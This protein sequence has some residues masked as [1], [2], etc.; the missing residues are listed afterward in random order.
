M[1]LVQLAQRLATRYLAVGELNLLPGAAQLALCDAVNIASTSFY[2]RAPAV[3]RRGNISFTL[4]APVTIANVAVTQN[5]AQLGAAVFTSDQTGCTVQL[6]GDPNWN[7]VAGPDALV[8]AYLGTQTSVQATVYGDCALFGAGVFSALAGEPRLFRADI[9]R[10]DG[11]PLVRND[12]IRRFRWIGT[13]P[14]IGQPETYS[15]GPTALPGSGPD[16][17][18]LRIHPLP[19][20]ACAVQ[21]PADLQPLQFFPDDLTQSFD[22]PVPEHLCLT[23]LLPLAAIALADTAGDYWKKGVKP[24]ADPEL[25]INRLPHDFAVPNNFVG[26]PNGW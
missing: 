25:A 4:P 5:S 11:W 16:L 21:V 13:C 7:Q 12:H 1:T 2:Q 3:Y 14:C 9:G 23:I 20:I 18:S 24:P 8:D 26:T 22:L 15:I 10:P 6:P 17:F 19:N